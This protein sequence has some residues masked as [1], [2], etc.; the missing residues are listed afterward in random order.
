MK[1][2]LLAIPLVFG[3]AGCVGYGYPGDGYGSYP[4]DGYYGDD[5]YGGQP[6]YGSSGVV[7]C[8]SNEGRTRECNIG[9]GY[10]RLVRQLSD[11]PCIE[12][13]TWGQR[14]GRVWVSQGCRAEFSTGGGYSPGSGGNYGYGQT[15]R[16]ESQDGRSRRCAIGGRG[17]RLVRQL[18]DTRCIEGRNW[19]Y[20]SG[21]V[22]VS[23]GCRAEFV[24]SNSGNSYGSGY[25]GGYGQTIRCE[26][27]DGR[28]RR[29]SVSVRSDVRLIRQLSDTRCIKGQN[30][31]WDRSGIWVSSGCRAEFSVR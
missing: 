12:G 25:N 10:A 27:Q 20:D 5:Y 16:C 30:W 23:D 2:V 22:W 3:L 9:G 19:G 8:E 21:S 26:S 14:N 11:S 15:V 18:S 4:G 13:R 1:A 7:R 29:C 17:A 28:E 31:G 24:A 6:S